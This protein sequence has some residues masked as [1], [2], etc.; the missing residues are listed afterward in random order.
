M[1]FGLPLREALQVD[2]KVLWA[3][4]AELVVWLRP[5]DVEDVT[6]LALELPL[7]RPGGVDRLAARNACEARPKDQAASRVL[8][9]AAGARPTIDQK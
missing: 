4:H 9:C 8:V 6:V 7:A 3:P 5:R 1:P 2:A